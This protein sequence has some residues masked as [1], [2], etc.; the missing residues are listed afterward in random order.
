VS[1]DCRKCN[2]TGLLW[3][4]RG[5]IVNPPHLPPSR[6]DC[7][8]GEVTGPADD[9]V[10]R[11][12]RIDMFSLAEKSIYNAQ[13]A[14]EA[15]PPDV[16]L[17]RACDLLADARSLVADFVD[18]VAAPRA[19]A[20]TLAAERARR[21]DVEAELVAVLAE[22]DEAR[23]QAA[24]MRNVLEDCHAHDLYVRDGSAGLDA[25]RKAHGTDYGRVRDE[26]AHDHERS[27]RAAVD[28]TL[29]GEMLAEMRA[30]IAERDE[31]RKERDLFERRIREG[32]VREQSL[33]VQPDAIADAARVLVATLPRCGLVSRPGPESQCQNVATCVD[34]DDFQRCDE[35]SDGP[36]A[37]YSYAAPLRALLA[38]LGPK[39]ET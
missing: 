2:G 4:E 35:H 24:A 18:G 17:T 13:Q 31:T 20:S 14:V 1:A 11:R 39:G 28:G 22:R 10:P 38:L 34:E 12:S 37:V 26:S 15:M 5:S 3:G 16:R 9:R 7:R 23:A 36:I 21:E 29:G 30:A 33:A 6:C 19:V 32:V 25:Y 27:V 8:G